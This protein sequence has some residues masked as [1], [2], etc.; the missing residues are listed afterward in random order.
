MA[1]KSTVTSPVQKSPPVFPFPTHTTPPSSSGT[2]ES[3]FAI[4]DIS[5]GGQPRWVGDAGRINQAFTS[6]YSGGSPKSPVLPASTPGGLPGLTRRQPPAPL[7]ANETRFNFPPPSGQ[8]SSAR[9]S[10]RSGNTDANVFFPLTQ[11]PA[12]R[13]RQSDKTPKL[14][15][16]PPSNGTLP[17]RKAPP[18][19]LKSPSFMPKGHISAHS[20]LGVVE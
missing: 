19:P 18:L 4:V 5:P 10:S 14:A 16:S 1:P 17:S 15:P 11:P 6:E 9:P 7:S 3:H 20:E 8:S 2:E 13:R 12:V